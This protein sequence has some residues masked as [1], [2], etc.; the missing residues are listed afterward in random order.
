MRA[1]TVIAICALLLGFGP[2]PAA[3]GTSGQFSVGVQVV[4]SRP[5]DRSLLASVPLPADAELIGANA[6]SRHHAY[7]GALAQAAAFYREHLGAAG[8]RLVQWRGDGEHVLEQ[9]WEGRD[10]R[11]L[12]RLQAALGTVPATRIS[13]SAGA[14]RGT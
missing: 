8:W 4:A 6:T 12:L 5:A 13:L 7:A 1:S 3:A 10:G 2:Q 11:L 14:A 9:L